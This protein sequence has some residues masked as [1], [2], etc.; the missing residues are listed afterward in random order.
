LAR[1][2]LL[3]LESNYLEVVLVPSRDHDC[4][5]RGGMIRAVQYQNAEWYRAFC[6]EHES[7]RK[8]RTRWAE[9]KTKIKRQSTRRALREL[10]AGKCET[11]YAKDLAEFISR[12][13][14]DRKRQAA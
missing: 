1:E 4:A 10:I 8:D 12:Y 9:F 11:M 5:M 14:S 13:E 7:S 2:Y 6:A 3:E